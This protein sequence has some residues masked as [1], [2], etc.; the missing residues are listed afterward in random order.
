MD[1]EVNASEVRLLVKALPWKVIGSMLD[2]EKP[3]PMLRKLLIAE[4]SYRDTI[5]DTRP[6]YYY[7]EIK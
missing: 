2:T 4:Y 7:R 1:I 6:R 5:N 3:T